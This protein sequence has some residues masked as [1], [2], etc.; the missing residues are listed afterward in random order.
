MGGLLP[1]KVIGS[2]RLC[3]FQLTPGRFLGFF[4]KVMQQNKR[5]FFIKEI[6]DSVSAW[7][8]LPN[9]IFKVFGDVLIKMGTVILEQLYI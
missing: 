9:T 3:F 2:F 7:A 4:E 6:K 5:I 8:Q 1:G